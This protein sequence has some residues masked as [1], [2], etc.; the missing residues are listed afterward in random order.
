MSNFSYGGT[1]GHI[2]DSKASISIGKISIGTDHVDVTR[3]S[4]R[5]MMIHDRRRGRT[6][7]IDDFEP[8]VA[9]GE[10]GMGA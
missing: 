9:M 8:P 2:E 5:I 7:Y 1:I 4:R 3:L 10:V 6:G